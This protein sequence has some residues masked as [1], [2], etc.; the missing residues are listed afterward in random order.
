MIEKFET[1]MQ[2]SLH[3]SCFSVLAHISLNILSE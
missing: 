2:K 1:I 3:K